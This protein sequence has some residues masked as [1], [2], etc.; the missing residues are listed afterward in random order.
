MDYKK[1]T[2]SITMSQYSI[3]YGFRQ[4]FAV[5]AKEAY[6]WCTSYDPKDLKLMGEKGIRKIRWLSED[7]VIL[8]DIFKVNGKTIKKEK[9]VRLYQDKMFWTNTHLSGPIKYSQF[10]YQITADGS[11]ASHLDFTGLQIQ[12]GAKVSSEKIS[13]LAKKL[14]IEDGGAWKKL[15]SAMEKDLSG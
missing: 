11:N 5:P 4:H 9:L 3:P 10:T 12:Y 14:V 8:T 1:E 2:M 7:A 15:A 6:K 13:E